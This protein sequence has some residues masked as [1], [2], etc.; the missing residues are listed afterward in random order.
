MDFK[1]V[2]ALCAIVLLL[3]CTPNNPNAKVVYTESVQQL[4]EDLPIKI[5]SLS[6]IDVTK[7]ATAE[8]YQAIA[9]KI[10]AMIR[11]LN[12]KSERFQIPELDATSKGWDKISKYITEYGPLIKTYNEVI[13]AANDYNNIKTPDNLKAF[14]KNATVLGIEVT[15]IVF[16]VFYTISYGTVGVVYRE[17]GMSRMALE[18]GSCVSVVLSEAHWALRTILVEG[19]SQAARKAMEILDNIEKEYHIVEVTKN[20]TDAILQSGKDYINSLNLTR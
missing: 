17:S 12:E 3:G 5:S 2:F 10:N 14:Y 20:K 15:V 16:A 18:C 9:D 1:I 6:T 11:I 13:L 19:S 4:A 7:A 8:E